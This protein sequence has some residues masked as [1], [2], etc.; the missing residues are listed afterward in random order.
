[1]NLNISDIKNS[2]ISYCQSV[3]QT[4]FSPEAYENHYLNLV[5]ESLEKIKIDLT[6]KNLNR[7]IENENFNFIKAKKLIEFS[8]TSEELSLDPT[9]V[10]EFETALDLYQTQIDQL[11]QYSNSS[12]KENLESVESELKR[13]ENQ[14]QRAQLMGRALH[15]QSRMSEET[16]KSGECLYA[17]V[18][19]KR[20][21]LTFALQ[22]HLLNEIDDSH[23]DEI[24]LSKNKLTPAIKAR[25]EAYQ[26]ALRKHETQVETWA[27]K[28]TV[29]THSLLSKTELE[30]KSSPHNLKLKG[31]LFYLNKR[32]KTLDKAVVAKFNQCFEIYQK[33]LSTIQ[34]N[35]YS[36]LKQLEEKKKTYLYDLKPKESGKC[37]NCFNWFKRMSNWR[38]KTF[39]HKFKHLNQ[40]LA[41][42]AQKCELLT[43]HLNKEKPTNQEEYREWMSSNPLRGLLTTVSLEEIEQ[44]ENIKNT[45]KI[46]AHP[47]I[48]S[49][50]ETLAAVAT[51]TDQVSEETLKLLRKQAQLKRTYQTLKANCPDF[52]QVSQE[53]FTFENGELKVTG[54]VKDKQFT[55]YVGPDHAN[56]TFQAYTQATIQ[57]NYMHLYGQSEFLDRYDA[58]TANNIA[59]WISKK[60]FPANATAFVIWDAQKD[61]HYQ[62]F[63][64]TAQRGRV[65]KGTIKEKKGYTDFEYS[66][67]QIK[68]SVKYTISKTSKTFSKDITKEVYKIKFI[69]EDSI[70]LGLSLKD[71]IPML[72]LDKQSGATKKL[73]NRCNLSALNLMLNLKELSIEWDSSDQKTKPCAIFTQSKQPP[74]D[75]ERGT[76]PTMME[77][78]LLKGKNEFKVYI[79]KHEETLDHLTWTPIT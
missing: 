18:L 4:Y 67:F 19:E 44:L 30:A 73:T 61:P 3:Y 12:F 5:N 49:K 46:E 9:L 42:L 35:L 43:P 23:I 17:T 79:D 55:A 6:Q 20:E 62:V 60:L 54:V 77:Q 63:Y 50:G 33:Y 36:R 48:H 15:F 51:Q 14:E 59:N 57:T 22:M 69:D 66:R 78:L 41:K 72:G 76:S 21:N 39:S 64:D 65:P 38:V 52:K 45:F 13:S 31:R 71:S 32:I 28:Q 68:K 1:M 27:R 11:H 10:E 25:V 75:F 29:S 40:E 37:P 26:E 74:M 7:L 8:K 34:E 24:L 16:L 2:C 58:S 47:H 70:C 53:T 56:T